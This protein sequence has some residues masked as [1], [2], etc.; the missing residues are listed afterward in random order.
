MGRGRRSWSWLPGI[1]RRSSI[2]SSSSSSLGHGRPS[3]G[4]GLAGSSGG[5][6]FGRK[7]T[8][9]IPLLRNSRASRARTGWDCRVVTSPG[10]STPHIPCGF[11]ISKVV[12]PSQKMVFPSQKMVFP[13]KRMVFSSQKWFSHLK[14]GF[15]ISKMVFPS[16]K[17]VLPSQKWFVHLKNVFPISKNGSP[18][19]KM[20]LPSQKWFSH[21][22]KWFSHLKN[23]SP[24]SK[25][26]F[27]SQKWFSHLK[28][29]SPILKM[30]FFPISKISKKNLQIN[31]KKIE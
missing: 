12:F 24:I 8:P 22:K 28:N 13:S 31:K 14:N 4:N 20:V 23:C 7:K 1:W 21:L 19:S 18:I 11:L 15:P 6:Q 9:H 30:I 25:M 2:L 3:A 29:G 17:M 5:D 27:P 10:I 26:V 16:Q